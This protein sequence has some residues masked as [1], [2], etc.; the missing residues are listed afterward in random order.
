MTFY[1]LKPLYFNRKKQRFLTLKCL[2]T[3]FLLA[4]VDSVL[5]Q[6]VE[7]SDLTTQATYIE[8]T[9]I[10]CLRQIKVSS[11]TDTI[12][13]QAALKWV[14]AEGVDRFQFVE[15]AEMETSV[16]ESPFIYSLSTGVLT[17]PKIDVPKTW[18]T[19]RYSASLQF[20]QHT[21]LFELSSPV[22]I[23][24]NP[25]YDPNKTWKP[26][27]MLGQQEIETVNLLGQSLPYAQLA[28]AI[29]DFKSTQVGDWQLID[30]ITKDSGMQAGVYQHQESGDITLAFRGTTDG[31]G[32]GKSCD[33]FFNCLLDD[34]SAPFLDLISDISLV[35][36]HDNAQ[37]RHAFD[38]AQEVVDRYPSADIVVTGH[39]LGG[40]LA[41]ATGAVFGLKTFAFNSAPVPDR[42]FDDHPLTL[43]T[44]QRN[45]IHVIADIHD[46]V[47]NEEKSVNLYLNADHVTRPVVLNFDTRELL[48]TELDSVDD[49]RVNKHGIGTLIANVST[50]LSIYKEGW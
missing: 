19:E 7:C 31:A 34:I 38:Y 3:A 1:H 50:L 28:E 22:M 9:G 46:P 44:D 36:G 37:F 6:P 39:S 26:Y 14:G 21:S 40:G 2:L 5:S 20:N 47:S 42:F 13:Y 24:L 15:P 29:Y 35:F 17:L 32:S 4:N 18:G 11:N 48:P 33:G 30:K 23:Y 41:Q 49:L 10:L 27:G 8:K 25:D 12:F 43:T 16:N 45:N